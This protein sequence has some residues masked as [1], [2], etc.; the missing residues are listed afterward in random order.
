MRKNWLPTQRL[1]FSTTKLRMNAGCQKLPTESVVH[2][3]SSVDGLCQLSSTCM[4]ILVVS[5]D[6]NILFIYNMAIMWW[7]ELLRGDFFLQN[8]LCFRAQ[9]F[10]WLLVWKLLFLSWAIL[11]IFSLTLR[12]RSSILSLRLFFLHISGRCFF[13]FFF[14]HNSIHL[15]TLQ[16]FLST[17][18]FAV[19]ANNFYELLK[20]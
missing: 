2:L 4:V 19:H 9:S 3:C 10:H 18:N 5:F 20:M 1:H 13:L 12:W 11:L 14:Q 8:S 6:L 17:I 16:V 15:T 7:S